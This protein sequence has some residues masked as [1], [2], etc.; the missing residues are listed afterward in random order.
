MPF[1]LYAEMCS[2]ILV[3]GE[4]LLKIKQ[5]DGGSLKS[6]LKDRLHHQSSGEGKLETRNKKIQPILLE[7][8]NKIKSEK[9]L[10]K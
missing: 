6:S 9:I 10:S 2:H 8:F 4:E 5:T 3:E 1:F 7:L